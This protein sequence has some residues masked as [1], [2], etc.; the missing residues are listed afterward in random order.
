MAELARAVKYTA[1]GR[2]PQTSVLDMTLN[3][4]VMLDYQ[5]SQVLSG[6]GY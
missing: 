1:K 2:T 3:N 5:R 4:P 6:P